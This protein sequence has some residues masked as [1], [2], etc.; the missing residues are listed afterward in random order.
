[1]SDYSRLTGF[2]SRWG[3]VCAA[4][5]A[6][7]LVGCSDVGGSVVTASGG[8]GGSA[9]GGTA[10]AMG[11]STNTG[12]AQ[13]SG[14]TSGGSATGGTPS[15]GGS[16][17][18][19]DTQGSGGTSGG[20]ASGGTPS[21]GGTLAS[22]GTPGSGGS[23]GGNG[24]SA[25][26]GGTSGAGG[27]AGGGAG[28]TGGAGSGADCSSLKLCETFESGS[29]DAAVWK[30]MKGGQF[31]IAV[32]TGQA[33]SGTHAL[34]VVAPD[35]ANSAFIT[36]T[37]TFPASDFWGRAWFR[38]T[39]PQGGHQVFIIVAPSTANQQLRVLNRRDGSEAFAVNDQVTDKWYSSSTMIPQNTWFCYEWHVT[40]T[41]TSIYKDGT[42]LK[43]DKPAPGSKSPVSLSIGF[44][45]WQPGAKGE[46]WVDDIAIS[47]TQIGCK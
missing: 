14:G 11:G 19:T 18:G 29:L 5:L 24:G 44:Q 39:G 9:M 27:T 16:T 2:V 8:S 28:A 32:E 20:S 35:A 30:S 33:H 40:A 13:A 12:G 10:P 45:R 43:L 41:G 42:E 34:H 38:F 31:T 22:G 36:E 26:P 7:S 25:N 4:L 37:K 1:M 21:T 17:G 46:I 3:R 6:V 47:D 23:T 15:T